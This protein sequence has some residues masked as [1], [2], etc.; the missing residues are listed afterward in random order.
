MSDIESF[1]LH[2]GQNVEVL[3]VPTLNELQL[4]EI[5]FCGIIYSV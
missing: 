1:Y 2:I 5:T 4:F 3:D